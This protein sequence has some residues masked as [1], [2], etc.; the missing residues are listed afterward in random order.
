MPA[1]SI[2]KW[3]DSQGMLS[4]CMVSVPYKEMASEGNLG[5]VAW[6]GGVGIS[7]ST[8]CGYKQIVCLCSES[9]SLKAKG[10]LKIC[11]V[12]PREFFLDAGY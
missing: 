10:S 3:E 7:V 4:K 2:S 1:A 5:T 12:W 6:A 11:F 8:R 9:N